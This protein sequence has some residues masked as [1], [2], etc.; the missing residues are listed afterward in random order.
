MP[1]AFYNMDEAQLQDS[2]Y[3]RFINSQTFYLVCLDT[4][5][6]YT[7]VNPLFAS[8][9]S[10]ISHN[11]VGVHHDCT[12][13][14]D[15]IPLSQQLFEV[16]L[17]HP[18][19]NFTLRV[20]KPDGAGGMAWSHWEIT[21]LKDEHGI[22]K[23]I[24]CL[25]YDITESENAHR[26][27]IVNAQKLDNI[28]E[29]ITDGFLILD[30]DWRF[31]KINHALE[32]KMGLPRD[33]IIGQRFWDFFPDTPSYNY[34]AAYRKAMVEKK[35][36]CFEDHDAQHDRWFEITAYP[37]D[38]GI[39]VIF[40]D[41]TEKKR[42]EEKVRESKTK[43]S[44]I[45]DSTTD[46]NILIDP[47]YKVLSFNKQAYEKMKV[48]Y[49]G[50]QLQEGENIL[51]YILP[52]TE[53]D[54]IAN[55]QSALKGKSS[56]VKVKLFFKPGMALWFLIRYFPVYDADKRVIG[57]SF[58]STNIDQQQRQYEKLEEIASLYSHDI[59]RPVATI[60]GL[61]QLINEHEL[62][63]E[64][65]EWFRYLRKTTLELDRVIHNIVQKTSE[66][67]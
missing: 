26:T 1:H 10:F 22:V 9:F 11:F 41:I 63:Y 43:L 14:P 8:K 31:V 16:S 56:E 66:I 24:L 38:E 60:L 61:T 36:V 27:A 35:T 17:A 49:D 40:R 7:Y 44:A 21:T 18:E 33:Q 28:I 55:F 65:Q 39:T 47:Q 67:N 57:V 64:N 46:I 42:A 20:R 4:Q 30:R 51:D 32:K 12:I 25:G 62:S 3:V 53:E 19:Q 5:G 58:N 13:C 29:H 52:G 50:R 45:L 15:D 54:F 2:I 6:F 48:F 34:P 37:F 23:G 59:R